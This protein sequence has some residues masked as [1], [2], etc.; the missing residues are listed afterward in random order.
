MFK[1]S[2]RVLGAWGL[3][4]AV[5]LVA[6]GAGQ[7][8]DSPLAREMAGIRGA[9]YI[10]RTGWADYNPRIV[11]GDLAVAKALGFNSVRVFLSHGDFMADPDRYVN[12]LRDFLSACR[13]NSLTAMPTIN[14]DRQTFK[15]AAKLLKSRP[16]SLRNKDFPPF[17]ELQTLLA[18]LDKPYAD[19][20]VCWDIWNEPFWDAYINDDDMDLTREAVIWFAGTTE[21][22]K[23]VNPYTIGWALLEDLLEDPE[24]VDLTPV[25]SFHFYNPTMGGYIR[26]CDIARDLLKK[27]GNKPMLQ[28]ELGR[29]GLLQ[30]YSDAARFCESQNIGYYM[31]EVFARGGWQKIQGL[32]FEDGGLRESTAPRWM[33]ERYRKRSSFFTEGY[34]VTVSGAGVLARTLDNSRAVLEDPKPD[35]QK[36]HEALELFYNAMRAMAP[37][38]TSDLRDVYP[39]FDAKTS[40][41]EVREAFRKTLEKI[42][43][44]VR[45]RGDSAADNALGGSA[46]VRFKDELIRSSEIENI[47]ETPIGKYL[48]LFRTL[49]PTVYLEG[50]GKDGSKA[51]GNIADARILLDGWQ[52]DAKSTYLFEADIR[53]PKVDPGKAGRQENWAGLA[54]NVRPG[55]ERDCGVVIGITHPASAADGTGTLFVDRLPPANVKTVERLVSVKLGSGDFDRMGYVRL[56]VRFEGDSNMRGTVMINGREAGSFEVREIMSRG[57]RHLALEGRVDRVMPVDSPPFYYYDNLKVT[58]LTASKPVFSSDFEKSGKNGE[59]LS[60]GVDTAVLEKLQALEKVLKGT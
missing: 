42:R 11:R 43:P 22:L 35:R 50:Q 12:N 56:S 1:N 29:P 39:P 20:I 17:Y 31:W 19:V 14:P 5:A 55:I 33:V 41:A 37:V 6:L 44:Y 49:W 54:V 36:Q 30:P 27:H 47:W 21:Y 13:E 3:F 15:R 26:K 25:V 2:S 32:A 18:A 51:I 46:S 52:Y 10:V 60:Y 53:P 4:L 40:Q 28:T 48:N 8:A 57:D 34:D 38:W 58:D 45:T 23:P 9:N 7:N 16:E 24:L 59:R